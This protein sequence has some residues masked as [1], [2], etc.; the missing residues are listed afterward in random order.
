MIDLHL[1]DR[2]AE[3]QC[4]MSALC[5]IFEGE[6]WEIVEQHARRAWTSARFGD[7]TPWEAVSDRIRENWPCPSE[8]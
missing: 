1:G 8:A 2:E 6:P 5:T 7:G 4:F 3:F